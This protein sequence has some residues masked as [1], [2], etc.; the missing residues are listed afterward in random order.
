MEITFSKSPNGSAIEKSETVD[1]VVTLFDRTN[2]GYPAYRNVSLICA[3]T[4]IPIYL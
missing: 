4:P 1:D 3:L 2:F